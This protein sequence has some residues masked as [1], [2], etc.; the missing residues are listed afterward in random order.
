MKH[1]PSSR[2]AKAPAKTAAETST[3]TSAKTPGDPPGLA[4]RRIAADIVD[5]VLRRHRPLDEQ[6]EGAGAHPGLA[7]LPDR[8]RALARALVAVVLRRLGSLRHLL[9]QLLEHGLP[10]DAPRVETALLVGAA[11]ILFLDVPDHAAVDLAVRLARADRQGA[12]FTG[13]INAVL[14]RLAREGAARLAEL[15]AVTLDTPQWLMERWVATYGEETARAIGAANASEPA[16]DL[17]VKGDPAPWA[18]RLGGWVLPTGSVRLIGHGSVTALPGFAEGAWWVQDAAAALPVRLL[19]NVAGLRVADLCAA[20]GGKAAQLAAAGAHVT[21]VDRSP[22]RLARLEGNLKRLSLTAELVCADAAEWNAEPFDAVLVDAPCSSTGTIR[23]H[24]DVPWLKQPADLAKLAGLQARLIG[25]AAALTRP[26]GTL[27]YCTC[28]LEPEEGEAIVNGLLAY[29]SSL[30]RAPVHDGEVFGRSEFVT[31][32]GDLR[33]LPCH[34]PDPDPRRAG[35]DGFYA[36]RL[37]KR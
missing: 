23:R 2:P 8:D 11:Q 24:P 37:V 7:G 12:H 4:V 9:G 33:T 15:D 21:A 18:E 6:L 28:S 31:E 30:R 14:R 35:L 26:G 1:R 13:L 34:L 22:A 29:E 25:R 17:T 3:K 10:K 36:A 20:P 5:G 16:L 19:G 32:E 27:V